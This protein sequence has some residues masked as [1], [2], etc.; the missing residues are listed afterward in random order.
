MMEWILKMMDLQFLNN[1]NRMEI[2]IIMVKRKKDLEVLVILDSMVLKDLIQECLKGQ[3]MEKMDS[4][5]FNSLINDFL[6]YFIKDFL[7]LYYYVLFNKFTII[8]Y[9]KKLLIKIP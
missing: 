4:L 1:S 2:K 5:S 9:S 7:Y 3:K 8:I 6:Y